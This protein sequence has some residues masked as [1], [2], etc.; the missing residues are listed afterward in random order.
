MID[1]I[2]TGFGITIGVLC[3]VS[4]FGAVMSIIGALFSMMFNR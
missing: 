1:L 2:I 4:V 3:G